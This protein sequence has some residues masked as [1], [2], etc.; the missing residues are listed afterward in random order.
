MITN[1]HSK[2]KNKRGFSLA[3]LLIVI[4]IISLAGLAMSEGFRVIHKTYHQIV[5]KANAET[6]LSTTVYKVSNYLRYADDVN[7][8]TKQFLDTTSG[9]TISLSNPTDAS[10]SS[11]EGIVVRYYSG[12][13]K[14]ESHPILSEK[15]MTNN[16]VPSLDSIEWKKQDSSNIVSFTIGIYD[17]DDTE[18]KNPIVRQKIIIRPVNA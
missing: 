7:P 10:E 6:L 13:T 12:D 5:Q 3:E 15:T 9:Y 14:I 16:L 18:K 1:K 4:L 11:M 8:D 2:L 17:K